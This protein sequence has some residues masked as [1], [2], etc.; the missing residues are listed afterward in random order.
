MVFIL[1]GFLIIVYALQ[2]FKKGFFIY[3]AFKLLLVTNIT[4]ISM[5]G[6]PLLTLEDFMNIFF[7]LYYI[8]YFGSS[9]KLAKVHNNT[10]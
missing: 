8:L 7:V 4:L 5:P 10:V 2:R 9:Q 6:I 3:L 1:I